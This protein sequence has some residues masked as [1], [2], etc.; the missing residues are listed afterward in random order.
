MIMPA[1]P[2]QRGA[3]PEHDRE[4]YRYVDAER[5]RH[6]PVRR[7]GPDQHAGP[8]HA[9]QGGKPRSNQQPG[10]NDENAVARISDVGSKRDT[11]FEGGG[12]RNHETFR[13][14]DQTCRL[15]EEKD[16][17]ECR[18]DLVEMI[19]AIQG[20]QGDHL[21][22]DADHHHG[23]KHQDDAKHKGLRQQRQGAADEGADHEH[24]PVRQV[25]QVH[26]AEDQGKPGCHEKEN[27]PELET[28][29]ELFDHKD[30]SHQ[31]RHSCSGGPAD[32]PPARRFQAGEF[33]RPILQSPA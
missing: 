31:S 21:D 15:V 12:Q 22:D 29:Q 7:A 2:A 6:R 33:S 24:R 19:A 8:G 9:D 11:A 18:K 27:D 16:Q 17:P 23:G 20:S 26:D 10:D 5:A 4:Q 28:V 13:A 25:H 1:R 3:E 30:M 14:P 32:R